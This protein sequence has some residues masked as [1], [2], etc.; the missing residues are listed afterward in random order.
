MYQLELHYFQLLLLGLYPTLANQ[1][2]ETH[3]SLV[4]NTCIRRQTNNNLEQENRGHSGQGCRW[5]RK[6]S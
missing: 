3:L 1:I 2:H 5:R 4:L 6:V